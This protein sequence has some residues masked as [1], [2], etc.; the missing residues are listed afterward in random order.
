[1]TSSKVG[2]KNPLRV[3]R[4]DEEG[5][6]LSYSVLGRIIAVILCGFK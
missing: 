4:P 2:K 5:I 3:V 1:M 6:D